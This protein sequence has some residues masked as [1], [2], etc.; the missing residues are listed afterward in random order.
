M[1]DDPNAMRDPKIEPGES[2]SEV[3]PPQKAR[4]ADKSGRVRLILIV[5]FALAIICLGVVIMSFAR[6]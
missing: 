2:V 5:S 1:M 6:A 4:A 3:V